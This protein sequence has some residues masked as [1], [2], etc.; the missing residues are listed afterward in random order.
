VKKLTEELEAT[1]KLN[2]ELKARMPAEIYSEL[3]VLH[4]LHTKKEALVS[5]LTEKMDGCQESE[6]SDL[7]SLIDVPLYYF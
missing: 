5:Q 2:E 1:K 4:E 6:I 3:A 7:L